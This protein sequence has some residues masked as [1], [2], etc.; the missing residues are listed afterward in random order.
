MPWPAAAPA[1]WSAEPSG[2]TASSRVATLPT[3]RNGWTPT[4]GWRRLCRHD[5]RVSSDDF[6][7]A[8]ESALARIA[9]GSTR[10][11]VA[12]EVRRAVLARGPSR[13]L[14]WDGPRAKLSVGLTGDSG[15][16]CL[17]E[18][19]QPAKIA[20]SAE[21]LQLARSHLTCP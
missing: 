15:A 21:P 1:C 2:S 12:P 11:R 7:A 16:G 10:F 9:L 17:R 14:T 18:L 6:E 19:R 8:P 20:D 3:S 13:V 4:A 5:C